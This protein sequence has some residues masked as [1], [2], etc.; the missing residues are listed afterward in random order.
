MLV[1]TMSSMLECNMSIELNSLY[2]YVLCAVYITFLPSYM[3]EV[4]H[5]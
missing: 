3:F 5:Y 4:G 1:L 2:L